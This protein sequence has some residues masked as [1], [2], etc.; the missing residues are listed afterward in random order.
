MGVI[1]AVAGRVLGAAT[2]LS[3]SQAL[4]SLSM[5][6]GNLANRLTPGARMSA[7]FNGVVSK[8]QRMGLS[9]Q[10]ISRSRQLI[11]TGTSIAGPVG[12]VGLGLSITATNLLLNATMPALDKARMATFRVRGGG[13]GPIVAGQVLGKEK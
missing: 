8:L 10:A 5:N 4:A 9:S 11:D 1:T 13:G 3:P 2:N 12:T 7:N 6:M